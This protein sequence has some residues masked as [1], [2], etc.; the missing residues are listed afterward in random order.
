MKKIMI[1]LVFLT[2]FAVKAQVPG[3]MGITIANNYQ[4][5]KLIVNG[6]FAQATR[7]DELENKHERDFILSQI[8]QAVKLN[9]KFLSGFLDKYADKKIEQVERLRFLLKYNLYQRHDDLFDD[10]YQEINNI[11]RFVFFL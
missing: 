5:S 10:L 2:S 8:V 6:I 9:K 1:V 7:Y 3:L 11:R 4:Q